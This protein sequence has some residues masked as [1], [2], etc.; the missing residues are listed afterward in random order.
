MKIY[1]LRYVKFVG[2]C[3]NVVFIKNQLTLPVQGTILMFVKLL[4]SPF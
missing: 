4:V 1:C 3:C 2:N